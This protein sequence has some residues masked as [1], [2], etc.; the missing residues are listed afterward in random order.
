MENNEVVDIVAQ[1]AP[2]PAP[3]TN[4]VELDAIHADC[5]KSY[6]NSLR[7]AQMAKEKANAEYEQAIAEVIAAAGALEAAA[8][9]VVVAAEIDV[10]NVASLDIP[11]GV[12]VLKQ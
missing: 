10:K 7:V 12:V 2:A 1:E 6:H 8:Q 3:E 4:R 5:L 9:R 11:N